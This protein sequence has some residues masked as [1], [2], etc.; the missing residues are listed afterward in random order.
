MERIETASF[1]DNRVLWGMAK[2]TVAVLLAAWAL[3]G[4]LDY[5]KGVT[6]VIAFAFYLL[7]ALLLMFK[8]E[9][10]AKRVAWASGKN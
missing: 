6:F 8:S 9:E 1:F 4:I 10:K 7:T 3:S 2:V 5:D